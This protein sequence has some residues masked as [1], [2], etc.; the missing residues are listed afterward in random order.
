MTRQIVHR[1]TGYDLSTDALTFQRDIPKD[2][3]RD[4]KGIARLSAETEV[5]LAACPLTAEQARKIAAVLG[6]A[7]PADRM[8]YF[9]EPFAPQSPGERIATRR[10]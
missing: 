8:Q 10:V 3:W 7:L 2:R 9:L 6:E 4:A 1:L 5:A